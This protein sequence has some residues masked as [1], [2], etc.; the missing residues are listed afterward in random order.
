M[1]LG[2]YHKCDC[3]ITLMDFLK[4]DWL[5]H[6]QISG[7][8]IWYGL[9]LISVLKWCFKSSIAISSPDTNSIHSLKAPKMQSPLPETLHISWVAISASI[10]DSIT[11][12]LIQHNQNIP[13]II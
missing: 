10:N 13:N 11:V 12:S 3:C 5:H 7:Y 6:A 8:N 4:I 9:R 2:T 1:P